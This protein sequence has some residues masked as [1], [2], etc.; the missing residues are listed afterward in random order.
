MINNG[1]A[2]NDIVDFIQHRGQMG[3]GNVSGLMTFAFGYSIRKR[4]YSSAVYIYHNLDCEAKE[5]E[6]AEYEQLPSPPPPSQKVVEEP[7]GGSFL[8]LN[9]LQS[10]ELMWI[11]DLNTFQRICDMISAEAKVKS[12]SGRKMIIGIDSE[13]P[14]CMSPYDSK[15]VSLIQIATYHRVFLIDT[16]QM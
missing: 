5:S 6:A 12:T 8:K 16:L 11:D 4:R 15:V 7:R 9:D 2:S 13:W 14:C 10:E 3:S 1:I